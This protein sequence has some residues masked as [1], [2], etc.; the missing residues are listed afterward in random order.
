ME[1]SGQFHAP[2]VLPPGK[3]PRYSLDMSL[4]GPQCRSGHCLLVQVLDI[5]SLFHFTLQNSY[6]S[7]ILN[8]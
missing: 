2:A 5:I 6:C 3:V 4:G 1:V 7:K 8:K